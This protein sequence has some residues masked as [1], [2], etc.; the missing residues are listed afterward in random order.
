MI[1]GQCKR[2][3]NKLKLKFFMY[4]FKNTHTR[5]EAELLVASRVHMHPGRKKIN[6]AISLKISV[7]TPLGTD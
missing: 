4:L 5:A 2:T 1:D 7:C 6:T 3:K